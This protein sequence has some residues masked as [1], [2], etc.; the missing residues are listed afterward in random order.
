V[1]AGRAGSVIARYPTIAAG[2]QGLRD[3]G[4]GILVKDASLGGQYPSS[5]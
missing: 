4:F 3:A 2:I 1:P 5:A